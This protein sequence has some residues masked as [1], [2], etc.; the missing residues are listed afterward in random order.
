MSR[1][2][3]LRGASICALTLAINSSDAF[4]QQQLPDIDVYNTSRN[5]GRAVRP[6]TPP[7]SQS[8]STISRPISTPLTYQMQGPGFGMPADFKPGIGSLT[9]ASTSQLRKELMTNVG[10]VQFIDQ[11]TPEQQTRYVFDLRDQLKDT[12]GVYVESRY[13]QELRITMRGSNLTRDYHLR[14]LELLQDGIPMNYADGSGDVYQ[15]DPHYYRATEVYKGGNALAYGSSM[16]G[17]AI[18]F[19]SPTAYTALAPNVL[20]IDAGS[21][22]AIR[23]QAQASRV[24]GNFDLLINGTFTKQDGFREHEKTNYTQING[25][26]GYRFTEQLETRLYYGIYNTWQQLPG[27]LGL[28]EALHN[29]TTS[30][31]P[32]PAGVGADAF[33]S[34]QQRNEQ[35]YRISNKTSYKS[36]I[37][38]IDINS[39]YINSNL[40]HPVF[41]VIEQRQQNWG[42]QPRLT[43]TFDIAGHENNLIAGGRVWGSGGTDNWYQNFNGMVANPYGGVPPF[44]SP[45]MPFPVNAMYSFPPYSFNG[46]AQFGAVNSCFG[47]CGTFINPGFSPQMRNNVANAFNVEG[48]FEDRV[49]I[50]PRLQ[51]MFGAKWFSDTRNYS[52]LGGIPY[53][54]VPGSNGKNYQAINPK[55]GLMF[56]ATSDTQFFADM[57]GSRDVPDFIDLTQGH[58]P[59]IAPGALNAYNTYGQQFTP[60]RMQ[61]GWTGEIGSRGHWDRFSWDITYYYTAL[62]DELLKFNQDPGAGYPATTFNAPHTIH[63]GVELGASIDLLRDLAGPDAGDVVKLAQV[64]TYN[65]F[66]FD[67]NAIYG[68]NQLPGIPRHVLRTTLSYTR[69]DGV[70]LAPQADWVPEGAYVDYAHTLHAP[71]YFLLGM[72]GGMKLP[73]G[74]TFYVDG[75][76][77]TNR[78]WVSDVL[79]IANAYNPPSGGW[80]FGGTPGNPRVFYPGNGMSVNT[81]IKWQF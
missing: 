42:V 63:Q 52:M 17:G 74:M 50:I 24:V 75:R 80:T 34:N 18:N 64:W 79:T 29:P 1:T 37:G 12:P 67:N 46:L 76:N 44:G 69:P 66:Y 35:N 48:F 33:G 20:S 61:K 43:S 57:T 71:G 14:G 45:P 36:D 59:P 11:N 16:L 49:T 5:V 55:V 9:A 23:G 28:D 3:M 65:N 31:A 58:F 60:L 41:V 32:F 13:G 56:N 10:A 8:A 39:W 22:G 47:F 51:F 54:P 53:E 70:Y 2:T 15:I 38:Q 26:F 19:V 77:L 78:T 68:N 4:G 30:M 21:F 25:N 6:T 72:Q 73:N 62:S 40:Y 27:T 7:A 81:G